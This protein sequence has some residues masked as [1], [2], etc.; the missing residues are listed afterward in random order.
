[1]ENELI[2]FLEF[3][4]NYSFHPLEVMEKNGKL[5][6]M[7]ILIKDENGYVG[8]SSQWINVG[9]SLSGMYPKLLSN[10]FPYEFMFRGFKLQSIESFFQGIK[11]PDK[12]LQKKVFSYS[13]KEAVVIQKASDYDWKENGIIYWQ[14][15]PIQRDSLEYDQLIDELYISAIQNEFYRNAIRNCSL[16]ILHV[17]GE[18][19]KENTV[20]TRGEFEFML[21]CLHDFLNR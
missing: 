18:E 1:M 14:G 5:Y 16:P 3:K 2:E 15:E 7:D 9:Y 10:L 21:N 13:G 11:F 20:F 8:E 4:K 6:C 19:S 12:E 17:M